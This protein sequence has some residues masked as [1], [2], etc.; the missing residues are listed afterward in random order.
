MKQAPRI[1]RSTCADVSDEPDQT[2]FIGGVCNS[3]CVM[4]P[5]TE[6][7][8]KNSSLESLP[9][10]KRKIALM[11]P[12]AEYICVTGGE[13]T[14]L[15][16]GFFELIESVRD[17]F[18]FP[19]LHILTNGRA[20]SYRRFM[21]AYRKARPYMTLLG[22]PLHADN[23]VLHDYIS[24]TPGSFV[25]TLAGLDNLY[26]AD[27]RIELR[28][29]TSKLNCQNLPELARVVARRYPFCQ[30]VC[31]M[32]LEMMG[33]A[34]VNR[35]RVWIDYDALWPYVREATEILIMAGVEV[36]LYNY[37]LCV[38]NQGL[39]AIY[40]KS[41]TPSK[42]VFLAECDACHRKQDCGGFFRTTS[43]MPDI[44]VHPF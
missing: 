8:R 12:R 42:V 31:M 38:V 28:I 13:P 30:H 5:Y 20:F 37:P 6:H 41:I 34:M 2:L 23:A 44:T 35:D 27:E 1:T 32:G 18:E 14:L 36:K 21:D 29:V 43:V 3:N 22:I 15:G 16:H 24:Q 17:H 33:N 10:L 26:A 9:A 7:F 39:R 4:C 25:E 11:D 19:V 40:C